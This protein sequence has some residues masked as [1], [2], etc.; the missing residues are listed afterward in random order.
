MEHILSLKFLE[1]EYKN[2]HYS[3]IIGYDLKMNV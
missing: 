3:F 2:S 1:I